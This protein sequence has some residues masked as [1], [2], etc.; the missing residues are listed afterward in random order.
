M[1]YDLTPERR[2]Y[3]NARGYTLL[4]ACPGSGKTTSSAYK[5]G[6][7]AVHS[8]DNVLCLSFTNNAV[9]ELDEAYNLLYGIKLSYPH[10]ILTI[11]SF[12]SQY[13]VLPFWYLIKGLTKRPSIMDDTHNSPLYECSYIDKGERYEIRFCGH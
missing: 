2:D 7:L 9:N 6:E 5:L 1:N 4:T 8:N 13:I 12:L 10:K 11:D 3:I